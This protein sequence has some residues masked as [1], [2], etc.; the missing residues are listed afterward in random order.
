M[1]TNQP[2]TFPND[3]QP[4]PVEDLFDS[5]N[6]TP[7]TPAIVHAVPTTIDTTIDSEA[8]RRSISQKRL[9]VMIGAGVVLLI[10]LLFVGWQY[11]SGRQQGSAPVT[12][13]NLNHVQPLNNAAANAASNTNG[14]IVDSDGDGLL[15]S[16]E[17]NYRTDPK[18][19]DSDHDGL[20]D[21]QEVKIYSTNPNEKDTDKD[22]F[23]DGEEVRNFYNPNGSGKM[24]AVPDVIQQAN[25]NNQ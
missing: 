9:W 13:E 18:D 3:Q 6:P 21:R 8:P 24:L 11:W 22:G 20:S 2:S 4:G 23:P 17:Q 19:V 1:P 7:P 25:T 10:A 12:E 5:V 14:T 15:D 16:E